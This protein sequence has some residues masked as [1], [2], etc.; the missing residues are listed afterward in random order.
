MYS[1][2][3]MYKEAMEI[4]A[5]YMQSSGGYSD[6]ILIEQAEWSEN[7]KK[8]KEA[9]S[10]YMAIGRKKKAIEIYGEHNYLDSLIDVCRDL[11]KET[12]AELI[13][14]CGFYFRKNHNYKYAQ[15]AYLKLDD[16][17]S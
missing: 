12:E 2:L 10:I 7:N 8:Y 17:K 6:E 4:R 13:K 16:K 3:K 5:K 11:S 9:A 1:T 14:L 15:E